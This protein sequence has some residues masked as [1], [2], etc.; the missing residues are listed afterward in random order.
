[1]RSQR[2][3]GSTRFIGDGA[4]GHPA[5]AAEWVGA[6]ESAGIEVA[7]SPADMG[8]AVKRAMEKRK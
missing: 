3:N 5:A 2:D 8:A 1:L 7:A 4:S 6:L